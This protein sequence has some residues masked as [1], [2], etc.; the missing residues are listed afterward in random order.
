MNERDPGRGVARRPPKVARALANIPTYMM[1]DDH[2]VTDDWNTR[3]AGAPGRCP[4]RWVRRS[5]ATACWPTRSSRRG[6]TIQRPC[7]EHPQPQRTPEPARTRSCSRTFR[8]CSSIPIR[9]RPT[10]DPRTPSTSCSGWTARIRPVKWH[11]SVAASAPPGARA[12]H[13]HATDLQGGRPRAAQARRRDSRRP[14]PEGSVHGRARAAHRHLARAGVV[15]TH[16]RVVAAADR[17]D[18][19]STSRPTCSD[20]RT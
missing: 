18:S 2:E 12:R 17:G 7:Q 8:S 11:Y 15:P 16:L 9:R 13:A 1:F 6:E 5:C 3:E 10:A 20:G 4:R 19:S 14:A